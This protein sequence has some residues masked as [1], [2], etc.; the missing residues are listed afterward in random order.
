MQLIFLLSDISRMER[1]ITG[2]I[3]NT[4][5]S[6]VGLKKTKVWLVTVCIW[7]RM[8]FGKHL[9][10]LQKNQEQFATYPEVGFLLLLYVMSLQFCIENGFENILGP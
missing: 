9:T 3:K 8:D 6:A 10:V 4:L 2:Q 5:V 7:T 1:I